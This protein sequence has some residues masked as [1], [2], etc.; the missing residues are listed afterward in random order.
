MNNFKLTFPEILAGFVPTSPRDLQYEPAK[1]I[2]KIQNSLLVDHIK[3]VAKNSPYY[4]SVFHSSGINH[5]D[6]RDISSLKKIP[7]T[8]KEGKNY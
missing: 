6:I 4:K 2:N 1:E 7:P 3:Y 5:K 8:S